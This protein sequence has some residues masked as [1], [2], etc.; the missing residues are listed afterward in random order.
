MSEAN[1]VTKASRLEAAELDPFALSPQSISH[2]VVTPVQLEPVA[3]F[4]LSLTKG[5][6]PVTAASKRHQIQRAHDFYGCLV[7]QRNCD[8]FG[9]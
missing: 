5:P 4:A 7:M 6:V 1:A 9:K 8:T 3:P 2:R